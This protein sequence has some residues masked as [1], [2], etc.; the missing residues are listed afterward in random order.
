MAGLTALQL[1]VPAVDP[2]L[3]DLRSSLPAGSTVFDPAHIS[4]GYPWMEPSA[5]RAAIE[6]V[7]RAL[8]R[9]APFDVEL[10]GP[11][12]FPPDGNGRVT[13]WLE[14][15][16]AAA[17][18]ALNWVIADASGHDVDDFTP[19]CSLVRL[20]RDVDPEPVERSVR[21]HLPLRAR[22]DRVEFHVQASNGWTLERSM[23]LGTP[24][25]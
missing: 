15:Y 12:R 22:L 1:A 14:P 25:R 20:A 8:A 3:K 7:A 19:H 16:P 5:G 13:V 10:A 9:E 18:H 23:P 24:S 17:I 4:F 11:R 21:P 6:D 2:L